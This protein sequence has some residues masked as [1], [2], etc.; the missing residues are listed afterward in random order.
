MKEGA[1]FGT[2]EGVL[3]AVFDILATIVRFGGTPGVCALEGGGDGK[4]ND[5]MTLSTS[6]LLCF[7]EEERP[8]C[9]SSIFGGA[10]A[11]GL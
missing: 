11:E 4:S 2:T 10:G 3:E 7:D 6:V 5:G 1:S 8:G 9:D